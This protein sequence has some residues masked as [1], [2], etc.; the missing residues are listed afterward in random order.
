MAARRGDRRKA[1]NL[2]LL[3]IRLSLGALLL[4]AQ[5][6][7]TAM[8]VEGGTGAYLLGTRD[9]KMGIVPPPGQYIGNEFT[10]IS[11][12]V[13]LASIGGAVV[14]DVQLDLFLYRLSWTGVLDAELLGGSPALSVTV[15]IASGEI[16]FDGA[17]GGA[18]TGQLEDRKSGLGDLAVTPLMGWHH[19]NFHYSVGATVFLP[20][21]AYHTA[22]L[23]VPDRSARLLS[24]GKN[25]LAVDPTI[26]LTYLDTSSGLEA[27]GAVGVTIS[28]KNDATDYQTGEELHIEAS[29]GQNLPHGFAVGVAGYYYQQIADDSGSGAESFKLALG[30]DDLEARVL[31]IG[32]VVAFSHQLGPVG[33]TAK[34]KYYHEFARHKRFE[35]NGFS[36]AVAITW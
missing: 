14:S 32:P 8:A 5:M 21:G 29:V 36:F 2:L 1:T 22:E 9:L 30:T 20:T 17:L 28:A 12:N 11:G 35:S 34:A 3:S 13:G 33:M 24:I 25:K 15:P 16:T 7:G 19:G 27:S 18:I 6:P 23:D 4:A 31:G 10:Y 26:A